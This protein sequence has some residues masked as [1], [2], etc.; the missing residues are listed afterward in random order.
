MLDVVLADAVVV[1][2]VVAV[3]VVVFECAGVEQLKRLSPSLL[4]LVGPAGYL[5][6][7]GATL[8]CRLFLHAWPH[9]AIVVKKAL[10]WLLVP[11]SPQQTWD[12]EGLATCRPGTLN[13]LLV[14]VS[15]QFPG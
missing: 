2:L 5:P 10:N 12:C 4:P 13:C 11:V 7:S 6:P 15:R 9:P 8:S 3:L 14:G 1:V